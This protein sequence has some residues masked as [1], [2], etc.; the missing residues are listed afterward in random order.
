MFGTAKVD[1]YAIEAYFRKVFLNKVC[2][3]FV[4]HLFPRSLF[5]ATVKWNLQPKS[6]WDKKG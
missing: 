1:T 5:I 6:L 4:R 2:D 3:K